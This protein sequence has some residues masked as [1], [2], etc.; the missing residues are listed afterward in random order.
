MRPRVWSSSSRHTR[1]SGETL[2]QP[3]GTRRTRTRALPGNFSP[4]NIPEIAQAFEL[5]PVSMPP[6]LSIFTQSRTTRS[7]RQDDRATMLRSY[8]MSRERKLILRTALAVAHHR[9]CQLHVVRK[10]TERPNAKLFEC[11]MVRFD[12]FLGSNLVIDDMS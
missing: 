12:G 7:L 9:S 8:P 10:V 6:M 5:Y 3:P 11:A 1:F 4:V 2:R